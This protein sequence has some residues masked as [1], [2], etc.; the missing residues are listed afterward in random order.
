[1][2]SPVPHVWERNYT[3]VPFLQKGRHPRQPAP[4]CVTRI[5]PAPVAQLDR[6]LVSETKGRTFDSSRAHFRQ[7]LR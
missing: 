1:M 6:A 4:F 2:G 3:R 5:V 7:L